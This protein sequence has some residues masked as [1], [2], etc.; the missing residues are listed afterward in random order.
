M[1]LTDT[2]L[3]PVESHTGFHAG[4]ELSIGDLARLTGVPVVTLR[5]WET[6]YGVPRP[7]RLP[8]GHRRFAESEV[9]LVKEISRL[10]SSGLA[11]AA[12]V[13]Q[14][15]KT[16]EEPAPSVFHALLSR[17]PGLHQQVMRKRTML[18][19]TRAVEDECCTR[20][21]RPLLFAGFEHEKYYRKSQERWEELARTADTAIVFAD[22]SRHSAP[23]ARPIRVALPES[24]P[25]RREWL[26]VCDDDSYPAC[27]VGA[28]RPGQGRSPD[29]D[30]TFEA[31]WSV[32]AHVVRDAARVC[33]AL[34]ASL[35]PGVTASLSDRLATTPPKAS[36]DLSRAH[37]LLERVVGYLDAI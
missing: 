36:A 24:A 19:L 21:Q 17:H 9:G 37:R 18:A 12:A 29:L 34:A 10:R 28:E 2:R 25:L 14:A 13:A 22:F 8:S 32:D 35:A 33:A 6:R 7:H 1:V 16:V 23:D 3:S 20:A 11:L 4:Q 15:M 31:V 5:T 26:L 30:R 27:V